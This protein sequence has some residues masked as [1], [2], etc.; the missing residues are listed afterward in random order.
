[1][2]KLL[3]VS[4]MNFIVISTISAL[5][6]LLHPHTSKASRFFKKIVQFGR[7]YLNLHCGIDTA[8]YYLI[9]I[10]ICRHIHKWYV[11]TL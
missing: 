3:H 8:I 6:G 4:Y 5:L 11:G 7:E 10:G 1:M 2:Q 9:G